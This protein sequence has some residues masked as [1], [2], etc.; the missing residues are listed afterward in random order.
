MSNKTLFGAEARAKLLEGINL[1]SKSVSLT[2]GASGRNAV[3]NRWSGKPIITNDGISIAEDTRPEDLGQLQGVD[4]HNQVLQEVNEEAGDATTTTSVLYSSMVNRG[5]ELINSPEL[6]VNPNRL[7]KEMVTATK[8]VIEEIKNSVVKV[9]NFDDIKKIAITS[10]DSEEVGTVIAEAVHAAGENGIVYVNESDKEGVTFSKNEGYQFSQGML[11]PYLLTNPEKMESVLIDPAI[12]ITEMQLLFNDDF[13]K[14]I[15]SIIPNK[16]DILIIC[17]EIHPDVVKFAV[18]NMMK[19]ICRIAIVKKPMQAEYL[20][21]IASLVGGFAMT[22]SKGKIKYSLEYLGTADK[23]VITDKNTTIFGKNDADKVIDG[24]VVVKNSTYIENIKTQLENSDDEIF[25]IKAQERI[26]RLT[27]GIYLL[28]VGAR[29][30]AEQRHLKDKVD[31]ALNAARKA[32]DGYLPGGGVALFNIANKLV[33][34]SGSELNSGELVIYN[35]LKQPLFQIINNA[36]EIVDNII[37]QIKNTGN[38]L[39]G[40]DAALLG[41]VP[42]IIE[43]GI[44]DSVKST[45]SAVSISSSNAGLFLT[46]DILN[47]PIPEGNNIGLRG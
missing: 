2:L 42:N 47:V 30:P 10:A 26:A 22:P 43:A 33:E 31:D 21:D 28:N 13:V 40:Y 23:V 34:A 38:P 20:E 6:K 24:S 16:K 7:R 46:T 27:G 18:Q 45:L 17:D 9:E 39:S 25:K 5:N 35:S 14:F 15:G 3:F 37:D 44:T 41:V 12:L 4:L 19:G 32:K 1:V 36:G 29:T 8:K 11:S